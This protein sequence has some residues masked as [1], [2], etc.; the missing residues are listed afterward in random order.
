MLLRARG[1]PAVDVQVLLERRFTLAVPGRE[2]A[3]VSHRVLRG[4]GIVRVAEKL[5]EPPARPGTP[6]QFP[7]CS[8]ITRTR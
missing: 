3:L 4:V 5:G 1:I 6:R 8:K 2:H 7:A